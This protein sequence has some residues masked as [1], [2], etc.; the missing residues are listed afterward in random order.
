MMARILGILGC[1]ALSAHAG[2]KPL[3]PL[4]S[5]P[6]DFGFH[7]VVESGYLW[8]TGNNSAHDY[9]AVPTLISLLTPEMFTLWDGKIRVRNRFTLLHEAFTSGPED[10][11]FGVAAAPSLEWTMGPRSTMFL[12]VGGGAGWINSSGGADGQ[13]QDLSFNWFAH[14]G[15]RHSIGGSLEISCGPYFTHHSNLGMTDPNPGIDLFGVMAG[16]S[17]KF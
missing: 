15:L 8:K 6:D 7:V 17:W 10:Y 2:A 12:A 4:R 3:V 14:T 11:Y 16:L 9:E 13:G 1:A 5:A